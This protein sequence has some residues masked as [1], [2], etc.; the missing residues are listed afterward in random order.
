MASPDQWVSLIAAMDKNRVIGRGIE[1][2]WRLPEDLKR[3]RRLTMGKPI[4]MGRRTF[5]SIGRPLPGRRNIV[6]SRSAGVTEQVAVEQVE[7]VSSLRGALELCAQ[8]PEIMVIGGAAIY[9]A[10]LPLANR[11]YLTFLEQVF[12]G[13]VYFPVVDWACWR[14]IEREDITSEMSAH[15]HVN[16]V[17][18]RIA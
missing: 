5:E 6:V 11:L 3:F 1:L 12:P 16:L 17:F 8:A 13:D 7:Y 9:G 18:E 2:P 14:E 10:A 15:P 4:V